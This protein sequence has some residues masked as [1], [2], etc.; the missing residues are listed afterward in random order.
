ARRY[1]GAAAP[2]ESGPVSLGSGSFGPLIATD[3]G[4][5]AVVSYTRPVGSGDATR[6]TPRFR[7]LTSDAA[8]DG[9]ELY[10]VGT[11]QADTIA[12]T[13][14]DSKVFATRGTTTR[15]FAAADVSALTINGFGG[16][17]RIA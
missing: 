1:D 12:V 6:N 5:T 15:S 9:A 4:G 11:G 7:R 13:T 14:S 8:L 10:V 17:D 2:D 16:S 3:A